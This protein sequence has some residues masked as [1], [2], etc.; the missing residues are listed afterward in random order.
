MSNAWVAPDFKVWLKKRRTMHPIKSLVVI[1]F[2]YLPCQ[3][4]AADIHVS[5]Q[6]LDTSPGTPERPLRTLLR[7]G[8]LAKA[9]DTVIIHAGTYRE[10]LTIRHSGTADR[11]LTFIA[12]KDE[13]VILSGSDSIKDWR[14]HKGSIVKCKLPKSLDRGFNQVFLNGRMLPMARF[15]NETSS[16]LHNATFIAMQ[17]AKNH[18]TSARLNQPDGFWNGGFMV[19]GF[20]KKWTFQCA[21]IQDYKQGKL[22]LSG[23]S[24]PWFTGNGVG[25]VAG[26]LGALDAPGEW[27]IEDES[28]YLWP[29]N[30]VNLADAQVEVKQRNLCVDFNGQ[31]HVVV[32]GIEITTGT[33][34]LVGNSNLLENC[35]VTYPS[36][37]T[38][39]P[40]SGYSSEGG[41]DEGHNGIRIQGNSNTLRRCD[42]RYS[43]GSG[44]VVK[45]FKNVVTR[46]EI[47][48]IDYAGTYSCPIAL[49]PLKDEA[50]GENQIWFNTIRRTGRDCIHLHGASADDIR[51]NDISESGLICKDLGM[52]YAWGRDGRGTRIAYNWVHDNKGNGP[53]PGIYLDNYCRNFIV[54]HNVIWNC[55]A[56]VR[57][58]GP[59]EGH[60]IYNNTLFH[61]QD[62]GS[63]TYH[64]WPPKAPHVKAEW[65]NK[66]YWYDQGNNLFLGTAPATQLED[67]TNNKFNL[68]AGA[69]A[70]DAG[71]QVSG[72]T[73]GFLGKA[74]ELGAYE[75]GEIRWIPGK[76][77]RAKQAPQGNS[78]KAGPQQ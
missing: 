68:Q 1:L 3:I 37:F 41:V 66:S 69:A 55:E 8:E 5:H 26:V 30:D 16:D 38:R 63:R 58:N 14:P 10:T 21:S 73:Q 32:Q 59:T 62:I 49:R 22:M 43:A 76:N 61:C 12:A 54:D 44:V 45:G 19:G 56:G 65:P 40:W 77:G 25:Y 27:H 51:Y 29:P 78:L 9:G 34:R 52:V 15:P 75:V 17:A 70:I 31:S 23:Q 24:G 46:C 4:N 35:T 11:P 13:T 20:G 57:V 60:R 72:I 67:W 50:Y 39:F 53:N 42:V 28:L 18:I 47:S 48:D 7:A 36:H 64:V 2:L 74:P 6:G 71:K 33:V